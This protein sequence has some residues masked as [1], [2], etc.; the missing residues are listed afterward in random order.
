MVAG[1]E[2]F[3][4]RVVGPKKKSQCVQQCAAG[5]TLDRLYNQFLALSTKSRAEKNNFMLERFWNRGET[6]NKGM[7]AYL[8]RQVRSKD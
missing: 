4:A 5:Y 6:E 8:D 1:P 7:V 2:A 3:L